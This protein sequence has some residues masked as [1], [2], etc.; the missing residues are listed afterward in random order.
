MRLRDLLSCGGFCRPQARRHPAT[1]V[2]MILRTATRPE[3]VTL[4][5]KL[6]ST[7]LPVHASRHAPPAR[8]SVRAHGAQP[9]SSTGQPLKAAACLH[10]RQPQAAGGLP[11]RKP[12]SRC[13][14]IEDRARADH[15]RPPKGAVT[16][17]VS[18]FRRRIEIQR[19][20]HSGWPRQCHACTWAADVRPP[21][22]YGCGIPHAGSASGSRRKSRPQPRTF[23]RVPIANYLDIRTLIVSCCTYFEPVCIVSIR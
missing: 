13:S 5:R 14:T 23:H 6:W 10:F 22:I 18:I 7:G 4:A 15:P 19:S 12:T 9:P 17:A 16:R 2:A 3:H 11:K 1:A 20:Q 8:S 21:A